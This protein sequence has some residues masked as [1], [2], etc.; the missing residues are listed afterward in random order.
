MRS[1]PPLNHSAKGSRDQAWMREASVSGS[2][3]TYDSLRDHRPALQARHEGTS[4][5]TRPNV[6]DT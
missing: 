3:F 4:F 1:A 5:G 6:V 2:V